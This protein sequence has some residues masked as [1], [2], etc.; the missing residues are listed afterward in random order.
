MTI[1][2]WLLS[3]AEALA[4]ALNDEAV[5]ANLRDGL[6]YPYTADDAHLMGKYYAE[7]A[8]WIYENR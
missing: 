7:W 4:E 1:R 2:P 5:Q 6:P 3:D 8:D